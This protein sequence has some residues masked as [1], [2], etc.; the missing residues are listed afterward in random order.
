MLLT[1][2]AMASSLMTPAA[3]PNPDVPPPQRRSPSGSL[4]D[5]TLIRSIRP[6]IAEEKT[7]AREELGVGGEEER[8]FLV[9]L[10]M[11]TTVC[12]IFVNR[13][14]KNGVFDLRCCTQ[15]LL[16]DSLERSEAAGWFFVDNWPIAVLT[17]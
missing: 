14:Q 6:L 3:P 17:L 15:K 10:R 12:P 11:P 9:V 1:A 2:R 8:G 7:K 13:S 4:F 5:G 16:V